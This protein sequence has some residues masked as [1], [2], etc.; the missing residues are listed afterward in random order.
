ME[1]KE[2]TIA[3]AQNYVRNT[4]YI[5]CGE[6]ESRKLQEKLFEI[7]CEWADGRQEIY[8][9]EQPFLFVDKHLLITFMRKESYNKFATNSNQYRQTEYILNIEIERQKF[10]PKTLQPF[11]R[12]LMRQ[13]KITIWQARIFEARVLDDKYSAT[14]GGVFNY[15]IPFNDETKHLLRTNDEAPEFY[16]QD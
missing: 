8:G 10:D 11:D 13:D 16:K 12:V 9:T 3:E 7:G 5:V 14:S 2:M 4:K 6:D 15:C 1:T